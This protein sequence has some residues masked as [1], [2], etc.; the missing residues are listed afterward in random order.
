MNGSDG[1]T[2][3]SMALQ[4]DSESYS[5]SFPKEKLLLE[6]WTIVTRQVKDVTNPYIDCLAK[7]EYNLVKAGTGYR[8]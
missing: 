7:K 3:V 5:A 1:L 6:E 2:T 8:Y 4:R